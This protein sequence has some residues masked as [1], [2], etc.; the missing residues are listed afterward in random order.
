MYTHVCV[1]YTGFA[2]EEKDIFLLKMYLFS[3]HK[4]WNEIIM[5]NRYNLLHGVTLYY[6]QT[7]KYILIT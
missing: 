1:V 7:K 5:L 2:Q 4:S 3:I 6:S